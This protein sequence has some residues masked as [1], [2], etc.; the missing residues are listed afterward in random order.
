MGYTAT[1]LTKKRSICS[2][3]LRMLVLYIVLTFLLITT[4]LGCHLRS[5]E[6][7]ENQ[8]ETTAVATLLEI[9]SE[10]DE[11]QEETTAVATLEISSAAFSCTRGLTACPPGINGPGGCYSWGSTCNQG[12]ICSS[13]LTACPKG[14][15]GPGG[16]YSWGS[17]CNQGLICSSGLTACPKGNKGPGGCYSWGSTCNQG[18]ICSPFSTC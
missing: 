5:T 11:N 3:F 18:K 7:D 8:E 12:L 9:S 14:N 4:S 2:I 16:C 6:L 15:N 1:Q 13:G 17:T 10:L